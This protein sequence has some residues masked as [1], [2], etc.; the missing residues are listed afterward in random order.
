MTTSKEEVLNKVFPNQ[1]I[2]E[3]G[4]IMGG[5]MNQS[6]IIMD[7]HQNK[8]VLFIPTEQANEMV[9]RAL[10]KY[11]QDI[12]I[13]LGI[14]CDNTYFDV[15]TGIKINKYLD[16]KSLNYIDNKDI[17]I[18]KL[19]ELLKTLHGSTQLSKRDFEP[20]VRLKDY[21]KERK[22]LY[23][24][25]PREYQE[26]EDLIFSKQSYLE[27]EQ[28]VL[29]HN[30]FQKSNIM[31]VN[32]K[33][34]V[35]DFEFMMNNYETYDIACYGNDNVNEGY[36]LYK[37]YLKGDLEDEGRYWYWRIFVSLFWG[38]VALIKHVR[39][40]GEI[41]HIDFLGTFYHFLNN[42]VEAKKH[43]K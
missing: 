36:E 22:E 2:I 42:A 6:S 5:M 30:D 21:I 11:N 26:L 10:E 38:N 12:V 13:S 19:S 37:E 41:H 15:S 29:S 31:K 27:D 35:I 24:D 9:D 28:K 43:I 8:Y 23:P 1:K 39:G 20:F 32:D 18:T 33:Y 40:E 4:P 16:G 25:M 17:D 7:E 34:Y 3:L 14:T